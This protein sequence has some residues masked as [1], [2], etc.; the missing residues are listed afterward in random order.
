MLVTN[1]RSGP[2]ALVVALSTGGCAAEA[3]AVLDGGTWRVY[4]P[5]APA[6]IKARLGFPGE[7]S[8]TVAFFVRCAA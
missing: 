2:D 7:I 8:P 6:A 4:V 3:L 1:Q 5:H